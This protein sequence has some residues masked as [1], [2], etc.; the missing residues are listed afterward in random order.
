MDA[1]ERRVMARIDAM[2]AWRNRMIGVGI[3]AGGIGSI[4]VQIVINKFS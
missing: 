2:E 4:V 3:V 1:L